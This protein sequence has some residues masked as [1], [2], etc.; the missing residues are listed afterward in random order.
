MMLY[1]LSS[2]HTQAFLSL[3][4]NDYWTIQSSVN[5]FILRTLL[6][7]VLVLALEQL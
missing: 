3:G 2:T 1:Q 6:S 7:S 5:L 4:L